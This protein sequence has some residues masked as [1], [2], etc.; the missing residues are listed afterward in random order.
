MQAFFGPIGGVDLDLSPRGHSSVGR[1]R[2][3]QARG[4]RFDPGWLHLSETAQP[5][6][7]VILGSHAC[8]TG[9]LMMDHKGIAYRRVNL[10][11]GLHPLLVRLRGFPGNP[12][13][14]RDLDGR[15]TRRL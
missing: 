2:A 10:P 6:L 14:V 5:K 12:A 4:R 7:Y 13:P 9:M 3:L 15:S 8:R 1:A 11:T